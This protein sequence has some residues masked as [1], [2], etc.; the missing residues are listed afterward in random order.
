VP[1]PFRSCDWQPLQ[2]TTVARE[3]RV[4]TVTFHVPVGPLVWET[5]FQEPHQGTP[6]WSAG[7]GFELRA[8]AA[9]I[10]IASVEIAGDSV[11]ITADADLPASGLT[12][13]Y[14]LAADPPATAGG[15][16]PAMTQP[17][18]GTFRWGL[19]RDSDPFVGY[20]TQRA[21]PNFAVA[22]EMPV[23]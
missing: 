19:L 5:A 4:V 10:G 13:G 6:A 1:A 23:P 14:A 18:V 11:K 12:V 21:Q 17:Y 7:K 20:T 9:E 22:F 2:P 16:A 3:G 15:T 8:G